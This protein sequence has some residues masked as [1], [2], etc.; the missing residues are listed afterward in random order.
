MEIG[1]PNVE[2]SCDL[3]IHL[4]NKLLFAHIVLAVRYMDLEM[5]L[6]FDALVVLHK[7][8]LLQFK[9]PLF[10]DLLPLHSLLELLLQQSARDPIND[11]ELILLTFLSLEVLLT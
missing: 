4:L 9:L 8:G 3:H 6:L 10:I 11:L 2:D 5:L 7:F 1:F